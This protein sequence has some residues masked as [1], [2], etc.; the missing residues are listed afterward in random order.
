V[1]AVS[2]LSLP[3]E[4][5]LAVDATGLAHLTYQQADVLYYVFGHDASWSK[6]MV[7][8]VGSGAYTGLAVDEAGTPHVSFEYC[9]GPSYPGDSPKE[10][11]YGVRSDGEWY[12]ETIDTAEASCGLFTD[13]V[14]DSLGR[15]HI[16]YDFYTGIWGINPEL[17]YAVYVPEPATLALLALGGL[18]V[19]KRRR[20]GK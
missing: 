6:E 7:S 5:R 17:R 11:R 1:V 10:L 18:V 15:A 19:M 2:N 12:M 9:S 3:R 8:S 4:L 13:L 16:S 20:A 14:L